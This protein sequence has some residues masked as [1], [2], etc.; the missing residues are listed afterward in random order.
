MNHA[1]AHFNM[2]FM[3][4]HGRGTAKDPGSGLTS[5]IIASNLGL[6]ELANNTRDKLAASLSPAQVSDAEFQARV[7][8]EKH[9][10]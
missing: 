7:W 6:G 4:E 10:R 2:G 3:L 9:R 8:M 5:Y 1:K